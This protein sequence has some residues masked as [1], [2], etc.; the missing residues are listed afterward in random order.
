MEDLFKTFKIYFS[1]R[2]EFD[3]ALEM[4]NLADDIGHADMIMSYSNEFF[5][6]R[7]AGFLK[8]Q[9]FKN[10]EIED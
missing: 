4:N 7:F 1:N 2:E 10:I 8:T 5:R 3:S 9:G 6:D